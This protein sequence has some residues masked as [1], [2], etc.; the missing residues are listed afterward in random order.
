LWLLEHAQ[1]DRFD[2]GN[3]LVTI[4]IYEVALPHGWVKDVTDTPEPDGS[5][6]LLNDA[7]IVRKV[8]EDEE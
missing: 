3:G 1:G 8:N 2:F 4:A 5:F 6:R 7:P